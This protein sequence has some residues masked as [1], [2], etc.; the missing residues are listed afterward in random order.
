MR[1]RTILLFDVMDTLVYN[2][3]N[4][5]IPAFFALTA[6]ELM[7]QTRAGNWEAFELNQIAESLYLESYFADGRTFDHVAF[8][9]HVGAAYRWRDTGTPQLLRELRDAGCELHA[10]SNYP[11]WYQTIEA[12]LRLSEY[13]PWTFVSC[14][15]GHR[16]PASSAFEFVVRELDCHPAQC[17]LIDDV[18]ENCHA[19]R[20][21]GMNAIHY[22]Q[23]SE[24]RR[25]LAAAGL[26]TLPSDPQ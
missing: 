20:T 9:Q 11:A 12:R 5:E 8:L 1:D 16:K 7:Q 21:S 18:A 6:A 17:W 25:K 22:T 26:L 24:L 2:P 23:L 3:F 14:R 15:T 19:A 10:F 13:L 4:S